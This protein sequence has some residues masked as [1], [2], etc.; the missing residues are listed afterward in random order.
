MARQKL[1]NVL[2]FGVRF[3]PDPSLLRTAPYDTQWLDDQ[4][5]CSS[6][7]IYEDIPTSS[8]IHQRKSSYTRTIVTQR[9]PGYVDLSKPDPIDRDPNWLYNNGGILSPLS[10]LQEVFG[11]DIPRRNRIA[12]YTCDLARDVLIPWN[13]GGAGYPIFTAFE[14]REHPSDSLRSMIDSLDDDDHVHPYLAIDTGR[15]TAHSRIELTTRFEAIA[16]LYATANKWDRRF[17]IL[18]LKSWNII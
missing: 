13:A 14:L 8:A 17:D 7:P 5:L 15:D 1:L 18:P 16:S 10:A 3:S 12:Y 11:K 2:I 6:R 4:V 9:A